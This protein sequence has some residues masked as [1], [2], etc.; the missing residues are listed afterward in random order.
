MLSHA[1]VIDKLFSTLC[2]AALEH[3]VSMTTPQEFL[4]V[5]PSSGCLHFYLPFVEHS[6]RLHVSGLVARQLHATATDE[7]SSS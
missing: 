4:A 2:S 6:C 3:V 5:L 1:P 7:R